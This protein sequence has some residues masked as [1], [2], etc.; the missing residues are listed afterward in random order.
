MFI[1]ELKSAVDE[2]EIDC[3]Q[4]IAIANNYFKVSKEIDE[5]YS[6]KFAQL[7][8]KTKENYDKLKDDYREISM[9]ILDK[10]SLTAKI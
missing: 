8:E 10:L 2:E 7:K 6:S 1:V 5:F 9:V 4:L 3:V